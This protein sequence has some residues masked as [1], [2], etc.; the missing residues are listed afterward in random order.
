M[1]AVIEFPAKRISKANRDETEA[2]ADIIIFPGVIIERPE[3]RLT[4]NQ[5]PSKPRSAR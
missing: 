3:L 5:T 2:P 4:E 1:S